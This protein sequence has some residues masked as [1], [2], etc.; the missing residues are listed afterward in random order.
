[1]TLAPTGRNQNQVTSKTRKKRPA[2]RSRI[3]TT[4]V[5]VGFDPRELKGPFL[6][7]CGAL[8][9]DYIVLIIVPVVT[10]LFARSLGYD[11]QKLLNSGLGNS[12]WMVTILLAVTNFLVL[13]LL[14]GRSIGKFFTGLKVVGKDGEA[15]SLIAVLLRH[16]V[17]YPLTVLTGGLGFLWAS[18]SPDGKALHDYL[19]GT[20]VVF[21]RKTVS[22][23][24][25]V[26]QPEKA[27]AK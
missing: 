8:L 18:V 4:R 26:K 11:G 10:L 24:R 12:G 14:Y 1:M 6:L 25:Y 17:G 13:P 19:S 5:T 7:R 15:P 3:R 27:T 21:G 9:I 22:E 2:P 23:R 16:L 20:V